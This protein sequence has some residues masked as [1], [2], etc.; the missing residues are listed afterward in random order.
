VGPRFPINFDTAPVVLTTYF[1]GILLFYSIRY[2]Y[3]DLTV[4]LP[5]NGD[6]M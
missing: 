1:L 3:R 4:F 2:K 6:Y 5:P